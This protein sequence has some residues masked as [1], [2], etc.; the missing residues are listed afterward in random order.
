MDVI[1]KESP[2]KDFYKRGHAGYAMLWI[3]SNLR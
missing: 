3:Y 1:L 2:Q